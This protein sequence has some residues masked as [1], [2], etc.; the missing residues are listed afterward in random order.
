M[1]LRLMPFLLLGTLLACQPDQ[2]PRLPQSLYEDG[3]KL[4]VAGKGPEARALWNDLIARYPDSDAAQRAKKDLFFVNA[5]IE[6][7]QNDRARA[8]RAVLAKVVN[9]LARYREKRG[10]YPTSL[11]DLVP[12]YLDQVP[13]AS[14]GHPFFY[15]SYVGQPIVSIIPK[16]GPA[17]QLFN[18][19]LDHYDLASLGTD[20]APGGDGLAKDMLYHDGDS[21]D[22]T[23][24]DPI[25][26]PQPLRQ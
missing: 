11:N 23:G 10:E 25:P 6:R 17:R 22:T 3:R 15:R 7:D 5:M 16:R 21:V 14:W 26:Q 4:N 13:M 8:T 19:K 9:A 20:L 12:E 24:F 2:D 18:T 1:S